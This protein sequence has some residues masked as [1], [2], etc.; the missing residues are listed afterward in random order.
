MNLDKKD[1]NTK[2]WIIRKSDQKILKRKGWAEANKGK[3]LKETNRQIKDG[4][5]G[6]PRDTP[7]LCGI[8]N[9]NPEIAEK[10]GKCYYANLNKSMPLTLKDQL[11][12][13][14]KCGNDDCKQLSE[15]YDDKT[16]FYYDKIWNHPSYENCKEDECYVCCIRDCPYKEPFHHHH[17]GCPSCISAEK[18]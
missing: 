5:W 4:S 14:Q 3:T 18:K 13:C 15:M 12:L 17:D 8:G 2:K 1:P 16:C 7:H 9:V 6:N 10:C 11:K